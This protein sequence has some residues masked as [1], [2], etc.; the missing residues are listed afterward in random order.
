MR[1]LL[2]WARDFIDITA[3]G[4]E[5]AE[6]MEL[7]GFEVA[8][9]EPI[10]AEDA[11]IDF[12]ITAN[13]PD[14]LSVIGLAREIAVVYG[15]PMRAMGSTSKLALADAPTGSSPHLTVAV[16]DKELCPRYSAAVAD[17][18]VTAPSPA[19]MTER[20]TA[21]GVRPISPIVDVTNYV[22]MELGHP[23]HAFDLARIGGNTLRI[24]R[25]AAGETITTLDGTTRKLDDRMLVIADAALPQ[26][27]AGVMGGA[28]SEVTA[29]TSRVAF[30][31]AFFKPSSVRRTSKQLNLRTEASFRFE[32]GADIE[33]PVVALRRALALMT[34]I[35]AGSMAGPIVDV[36]SLP[37]GVSSI[38]LRRAK[39][40]RLLGLD[41]P[42]AEV[43]RILAAL[44]CDVRSAADGWDVVAPSFRVDIGREVD[45]I[46][47]V[48][49]HYGYD[50]LTPAFP[51]VTVAAP[52]PDPRVPRDQLV[53]RVLTAAGADEAVT[54]GF[55][56]DKA[57]RAFTPDP[58][59]LVAIA[60]PLSAKFSTLRPSLLPGLVDAVAYNRRHG[61]REVSL[62]EIGACFG[63]AKGERRAVAVALTGA[64]D[65]D[66]WSRAPRDADF[67]DAKGMV[68]QLCRALDVEVRFAAANVPFL[69]P[70]QAATVLANGDTVVGVVGLVN[71]AVAEERGAPRQDRIVV[72][73]LDLDA[74]SAHRVPP[75][76]EVRPLPRFPAV[77][78]DLSILVAD[79]LPA[80]IIRGTIQTV[81]ARGPA[82][83]V[84]IAFFDR[85]KGKGLAPDVVSL[86]VRL[87]FQ[88]LER[89]LTD[90]DVQQTFDAIVAALASR[91][92]AEQR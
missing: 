8:S 73:E 80:E 43:T 52:P 47:E 71:A 12:E 51:P 89:T 11:V 14:C 92:G 78:R 57:A 79:A 21:A 36:Y 60:N 15:L 86:S 27:V 76:E 38:R 28:A 75:A 34:A 19:W 61:R 31:S 48:G 40:A 39:L 26:A 9:V 77:V 69:T 24:R 74:L 67:F 91:H 84:S 68:E 4:A 1:L 25:A 88:S 70:G 59:D 46:E 87:T 37:R 6:K 81:G 49:R 56:E 64:L 16:E 30:E 23:L 2:S 58:S 85:Y 5:I 82:P 45:L 10:G 53:R 72:A 18:S 83:L 32:R 65:G 22:L 42:D 29:S 44:G 7:R 41:I 90:S 13:R 66:D 17:I 33:A 50:R 55:V 20:L 3:S 54:F 35:G 62:F 63:A